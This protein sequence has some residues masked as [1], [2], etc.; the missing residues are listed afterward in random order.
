[1]TRSTSI[2]TQPRPGASLVS[3]DDRAFPLTSAALVARAEGGLADSRLIQTYSNPYPE[4][5]EVI[6]TMPLPA[7]GAVVGYTITIG[8][9]VITGEIE[10]RQEAQEDYQ[11]A[12]EAGRTAGLLDQERAD[13]FTQ[14]LG[15][16][17][18]G[19]TA[20]ID[21]RVLHPLAFTPRT[22]EREPSWE[23]RFPTVVGVRY[24]GAPGRVPDADTLD[25]DRADG[26]GTPLRLVLDL[27]L[28]DGQPSALAPT[29]A[30]HDITTTDAADGCRVRL[31]D[32][33]PLDR[34]LVVSWRATTDVVAVRLVEGPGLPGD[35]GR[36]GLLTI[37]P[38]ARPETTFDRDLTLLI[39][40]S[41]SMSGE[42]LA[43]A[44][45]VAEALLTGLGPDDRF[46]LMV[47]ADRPAHLVKGPLKASPANVRR[48]VKRLR[49]LEAGGC[50]E[51]A[52]AITAALE[53]LRD[54]AQRQV[55]LF[56]DGYIGF[57]EQVIGAIA[58]GLRPGCRVHAVGVGSAPNRAL[59]RGVARAGRGAELF[60][61]DETD[62]RESAGRLL[63]ATV[64]PLLTDLIVGGAACRTVA[65]A[66][67]R[68]VMAGQP[69]VVAVELE[70]GAKTIEVRGHLAGRPDP[71][72]WTVDASKPTPS[73]LPV[74]ALFGREAVEDQ[75]LLLAA[76][77]GEQ[78]A[79]ES[80]IEALGLRHRIPTRRTSLVAIADEPAVDPREPRRRRRLE[81]ELPA[82]VSAE[83]VGLQMPAHAMVSA[84]AKRGPG[85]ALQHSIARTGQDFKVRRRPLREIT[86]GFVEE[87]LVE[88]AMA[89]PPP[90]VELTARVTRVEDDL[91]V[92]EF[93]CPDDGF[94]LPRDGEQIEV[95]GDGAG[96]P[97]PAVVD[98]GISTV[99][100]PHPR[101]LTLRLALRYLGTGTWPRR[102]MLRWESP[103]GAA[104]RL[105]VERGSRS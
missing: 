2:Q 66:K 27:H 72:T 70:P 45:T 82:G 63:R 50:T 8:D 9:R 55:V 16:V 39:D 10:T 91:L 83:G 79:I 44:K 15:N 78:S 51:M 24:E 40:A 23:Y 74:G 32:A 41:G 88:S 80:V 5:L 53:P 65:P 28:A 11:R 21:I 87:R 101:G 67:P 98:G 46:E 76:N 89:G 96:A 60:V 19:A 37:T 6:Y 105:I 59:T 99:P 35:D 93:E 100:G 95:Y 30:S 26:R 103:E 86:S 58:H 94:T 31:G 73:E 12:L 3:V 52:D 104:R 84:F 18:A 29:S 42:P 69:L 47:F 54:D 33:A 25:V 38:P 57:E 4:A 68:D 61:A 64:G 81:V 1:M 85:P 49:D 77:P 34:D 20:E 48:A 7:D 90:A 62:A 97:A 22:G 14:K 75:E 71:W 92:I 36:Y 56:T 17:P 43:S 13:T 102:L